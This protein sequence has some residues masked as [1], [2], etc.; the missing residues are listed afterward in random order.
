MDKN[1]TV[2][3]FN[4]IDLCL[5]LKHKVHFALL[6]RRPISKGVD[7]LCNLVMSRRYLDIDSVRCKYVVCLACL[8]NQSFQTFSSLFIVHFL[9]LF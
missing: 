6:I 8:E 7:L 2:L 4:N 3:K 1:K 9:Y 5:L